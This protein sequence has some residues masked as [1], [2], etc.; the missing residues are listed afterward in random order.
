MI[1][2]GAIIGILGGGQLG[3]MTS[4]EAAKLGFKAHIYNNTTPCL[5]N[6]FHTHL[7]LLILLIT[8]SLS[9]LL[10]KLM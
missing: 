2:K 6:M 9:V 1:N 3:R 8:M 7:P 5:L 10:A 4:L